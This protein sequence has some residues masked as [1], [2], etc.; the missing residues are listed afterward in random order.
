MGLEEQFGKL[1]FGDWAGL[2]KGG[3]NKGS[4]EFNS[5]GEGLTQLAKQLIGWVGT[6]VGGTEAMGGIG[7]LFEGGGAAEGGGAGGFMSDLGEGLSGLWDKAGS[8]LSGLSGEETDFLS[9]LGDMSGWEESG[10]GGSKL[11]SLSD[12]LSQMGGQKNQSGGGGGGGNQSLEPL[13][14]LLEATKRSAEDPRTATIQPLPP[15]RS[16]F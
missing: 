2:G 7:A 10:S 4:F 15:M 9:G 12:L 11:S 14:K 5:W 6:A 8:G 16:M 3:R 13:Y 1:M